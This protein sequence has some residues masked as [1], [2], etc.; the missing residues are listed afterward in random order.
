VERA[1]KAERANRI[2][3]IDK[4]FYLADE[5]QILKGRIKEHGTGTIITAIGVMEHRIEELKVELRDMEK[6]H[7]WQTLNNERS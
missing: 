4:I 6:Q 7:V 3:R 5:I 2:S 1:V